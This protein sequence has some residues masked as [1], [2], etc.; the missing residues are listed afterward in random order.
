[1]T[2][3]SVVSTLAILLGLA[4]VV[5]QILAMVSRRSA[6]GQSPLGWLLG[7]MVN[8]LMAYVNLVGHG[9][10]ELAL[11]NAAGGSLCLVAL[12]CAVRLPQAASAAPVR[13]RPDPLDLS[14]GDLSTGDLSEMLTA[15]AEES[16]RREE[17]RRARA[18][19]EA[20]R[21]LAIA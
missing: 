8:L 14:T 6:A 21:E 20:E 3:L 5:P 13:A 2:L 4:G 11:G 15:L 7:V 12:G 18:P 10:A 1:M 17:R 9:A 16:E 19:A